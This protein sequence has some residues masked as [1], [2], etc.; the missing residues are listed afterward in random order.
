MT[1]LGT[2][3]MHM[4]AINNEGGFGVSPKLTNIIT[5]IKHV[6]IKEHDDDLK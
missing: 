6:Q 1:R 5:T 3:M 4:M 2:H